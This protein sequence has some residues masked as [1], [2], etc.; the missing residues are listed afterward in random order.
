MHV[1]L[2]VVNDKDLTDILPLFPK[3][4]TYYFCRPDISR[5]LDAKAL[6]SAAMEYDLK[7]EIYSSVSTAYDAALANANGD[8]FIYIG[9]STF[10]VAE[11][12]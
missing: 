5:G 3:K 12:L 11:I 8:D 4:A 9:G 2:G 6:Q 7:G 10:V 1:V